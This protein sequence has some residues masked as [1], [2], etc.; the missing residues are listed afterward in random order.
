METPE[1]LAG[2]LRDGLQALRSRGPL[3]FDCATGQALAD[4]A[5]SLNEYLAALPPEIRRALHTADSG[6]ASGGSWVDD[7]IRAQ[8][9]QAAKLARAARVLA[10][11]LGPDGLT[12]EELFFIRGNIRGWAHRWR[13]EK[14]G[15]AQPD[16]DPAFMEFA[17]DGLQQADIAGDPVRLITAA[18]GKDLA[19]SLSRRWAP[20]RSA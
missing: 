12:A 8:D 3:P 11:W 6:F 4:A 16:A 14:R 5:A 1:T 15:P 10:G 19:L 9:Q 2:R 7:A 18:L 13:T 20:N 17:A